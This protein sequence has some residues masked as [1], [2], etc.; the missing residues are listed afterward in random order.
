MLLRDAF[1][2]VTVGM[3]VSVRPF[4]DMDTAPLRAVPST[5]HPIFS[6]RFSTDGWGNPNLLLHPD[7]MTTTAGFTVST[8][9]S[10]LDVLLP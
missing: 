5:R 6:Y 7:D 2:S 8:N 10:E 3:I 1:L 4:V 9:Q